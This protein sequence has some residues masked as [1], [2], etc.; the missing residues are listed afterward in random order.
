MNRRLIR[1]LGISRKLIACA[2]VCLFIVTPLT[3]A[4]AATPTDHSPNESEASTTTTPSNDFSVSSQNELRS[5]ILRGE[6][7][8]N[9][10]S[11][12]EAVDFGGDIENKSVGKSDQP[13][14]SPDPQAKPGA[15]KLSSVKQ[16]LPDSD[17][18]TGALVYSLPVVTSPGRNGIQPDLN[19]TYNSQSIA[20]A[21][22]LG[23]GW[24]INI[25]QIERINR[26]GADRLYTENS[27]YSALS[28]ELVST[29]AS[30][31]AAKVDNGEFLN[32]TFENSSWAVV[33]KKGTTYKFGVSSNTRQDD[34]NDASKV[35]AW[36]LEEA[37][38]TNNN[39]IRYEYFKD[40]G[41]LYPS[42]IIYTGHGMEDGV[43]E[44]IFNREAADREIS[45]RA[46][47][48]VVTQYR[49]KSI[50]TKFQG[51]LV[52]QYDLSY[53]TAAP[54][55]HQALLTSVTGSSFS[56][57]AS[58]II[59]TTSFT[60]SDNLTARSWQEDASWQVP[61]DVNFSRNG[62]QSGWRVADFNGDGLNDFIQC[63]N[64]DPWSTN[65]RQRFYQNTG[66]GWQ[67][68][69]SWQVPTNVMSSWLASH[70]LDVNGDGL[71][72]ILVAPRDAN[73]TTF[74][75]KTYLNTGTGW[76]LDALR[77]VPSDVFLPEIDAQV[78]EATWNRTGWIV[79]DINGDNLPDFIR[80]E[81]NCCGDPLRKV[82]LNTG[83]GWVESTGF[84]VP[85]DIVLGSFEDAVNINAQVAD[86]NGDGLADIIKEFN[87]SK[88]YLN[89]G[90]G[91][92][93][94][95][96]FSIPSIPPL[97]NAS[98]GRSGILLLDADGDGYPDLVQSLEQQPCCDPPNYY[99]ATYTN[100][101][102]GWVQDSGGPVAPSNM[103][104]YSNVEAIPESRTHPYKFAD[105]N[106]D[107]LPD[108]IGAF[109]S[110]Y[111]PDEGLT[112][113][114]YIN[115][116]LKPGLLTGITY[117]HGGAS[118][119]LY[120][121]STQYNKAGGPSNPNLPTVL[122]TVSQ[123]A[124]SDGLGTTS[125]INY[126]YEAGK[127]YYAG[128]F[129][130][131][132]AGFGKVVKTNGLGHSMT[133]SYHQGD[134]SDSGV[135]EYN[136]HFSKIGKAY[137]TEIANSAGQVYSTT[138]N[139]WE[140][141]DLGSGRNFVKLTQ[142]LVFV[143]DGNATHKDKAETY[144]YDDSTGNEIGKT[145]WGEVVGTDDG[146]FTDAGTDGFM[147]TT[148]YASNA[149]AGIFGLPAHTITSDQSSTKVKEV[150]YYYDSL[151]LGGV[152]KGN[153]TKQEQWH[154][155]IA[156]IN[157]QKSY[158]SYGLVSEETD[159]NG[160]TTTYAYDTHNL[161]PAS[162]T[163]AES[164]TTRFT[165]D[166]ASGKVLQ[167]TDPNGFVFQTLYDGLGR[168]IEEKQPDLNNPSNSV[169]KTSYLYANLSVGVSAKRTDQMD[170]TNSVDAYTYTDG[171]D[172]V[173]Q[174]RRAAEANDTFSV[175]DYI[176][177]SVGLLQKESLPY[178]ST[179]SSRAP[180]TTDNMLYLTYAYD[181]MQR[182]TSV[183]NAVGTTAYAYDDWKRTITDAR[184]KRRILYTDAYNN[185]VR[186]DEE[187]APGTVFTTA[188]SY[189]GLGNLTKITDAQGNVRDFTY[190]G[191][192]R[193]LTAEDLH[194]PA[195]TT[196]GKW[197]FNYDA[198]GNL[199]ARIDPNGNVVKYKYDSINRV[200]KEAL[201]DHPGVKT[202]YTYDSCLNGIGK[203]CS[204]TNGG[205]S[206]SRQYNAL[207]MI[208]REVKTIDSVS[209]Q[210]DYTYDRLGNPLTITNPDNSQVKHEYNMAGLLE[211]VSYK[212][213]V[214]LNFAAIVTNFDYSPQGQVGTIDYANGAKTTNTYDAGKLYRLASKVTVLAGA[215]IQDM[216]Y[217]YDEVGNITKIT[218]NS[219][220]HTKKTISYAYD[221]L[222][223][224][225]SATATD[226][227]N[228][229][230]YTQV[231]A[232]DAIGNI[233][234][235]SDVGVYGYNGSRI[236][237]S[238]VNPHA[239]TAIN[240]LGYTYDKNGNLLKV[241]RGPS[242]TWDYNNR[243]VQTVMGNITASY[244]YDYSGQRVKYA[245]GAGTTVYPSKNYNVTGTTA[246]K[247]IFAGDQ[248]IATV[249]GG[250]STAQVFSIHTDHLTGSNVI[251]NDSSGI[252]EVTDYYPFGGI[253][254]DEKAGS[255]SEQRKFTGQEYDQDTALTYMN[256]RYYDGKVGRFISQ[257]PVFLEVG[258]S[259]F[260]SGFPTNWRY[261]G[262]TALQFRF[263]SYSSDQ[264]A[265][266][267]DALQYYLGNPQNLNSYSYA[268]NNPLKYI[269]PDGEWYFLATTVIGIAGGLAGQY[270]DDVA[271]N[272]TEGR[273][274]WSA[275]SPRSSK[276]D[277]ALAGAAGGL[278][279][280]ATG[281]GFGGVA[282]D[283]LVNGFE[284]LATDYSHS[285]NSFFD[286]QA[287]EKAAKK[288]VET[289]TDK[290]L[291]PADRFSKVPGR[292]P[293]LTKNLILGKHTRD[294]VIRQG[295]DV[296]SGYVKALVKGQGE[297]KKRH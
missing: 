120:K 201:S 55:S 192:G 218:D 29:G 54:G 254:L 198:S 9:P 38:D 16:S 138:V 245:V 113:K 205:A 161:Y 24:S 265:S 122:Y 137:R 224:L 238:Y 78:G 59:L 250:G 22:I 18:V 76:A 65:K 272:L 60:Y 164:Q 48:R 36:E 203:L 51:Q 243:L 124:H 133:T 221:S 117:P 181:P 270:L 288:S 196:F 89:T 260:D 261:V 280:L 80:S 214:W 290:L 258:S 139:K 123:I 268:I 17:A 215:R 79:A 279:G 8:F 208:A 141:V 83:S 73:E 52:K 49:L 157:S 253:R 1:H 144:T 183:T 64:C 116:A 115:S 291:N 94:D 287:V 5:S 158:N 277:Y 57:N 4:W 10:E 293:G 241:E 248:A 207:G 284:S 153:L 171:F 202:T 66:A 103:I 105:V 262:N 142:T 149:A 97:S 251:S 127:Y 297:T 294:A 156:Y 200:L 12:K 275:L 125:T 180:A 295:I 27:F 151:A 249:Q 199:I 167:T 145:E 32:Y 216:A 42:R 50:Q 87:D 223:R 246:T 232:Y 276:E 21:S 33:D 146:T 70:L 148:E 257:D 3:P 25:P 179:G 121:P 188:Y 252:E 30:S 2:L 126:Q 74:P 56:G 67:E 128:P 15:V 247:H 85:P 130:H 110:F 228:G 266:A 154:S 28:G 204:A 206:V 111:L 47:F 34:P 169:T 104:F 91:W 7:V 75:P 98:F 72:D 14:S 143:Y 119:I 53:S 6:G 84:Q 109:L 107:G 11:K 197:T 81:Y 174:T 209:F 193:R 129:D 82:Y 106:G 185:L 147:T 159:P 26:K 112:R 31:Y 63:E 210:T 264:K 242:N 292:Y 114:T 90:T 267:S 23:Q 220:T 160:H 269:D 92:V 71:I 58:P 211:K 173:I 170:G 263:L 101:H 165:Y 240:G 177:N 131:Q 255:F 184:G 186:V 118:A 100:N 239:I 162:V 189:N 286:R 86:V 37:R 44:V 134:A 150:R 285:T 20:G 217:T 96:T 213:G 45:Y 274:G 178:F 39:F 296:T 163:N 222:N 212:E 41:Q 259:Q 282:A 61:Q 182:V 77:Q 19:L 278:K 273:T 231:Y 195:D 40:S 225:L 194:A 102:S 176:Y 233:A 140:N 229:E 187:L 191:L 175:T 93:F 172:R 281:L 237:K 271:T 219:T 230:N 227:V 283:S 88:V 99:R 46:G 226:A 136:D 244:A 236:D 108:V 289:A 234:S 235:K 132:L 43:F 168:M 13:A 62:N 68:N 155:G 166:Y 152:S 35:F 190:D 256:A 135:G 95:P 69:V